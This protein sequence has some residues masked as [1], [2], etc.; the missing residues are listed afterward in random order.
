MAKALLFWCKIFVFA[1]LSLISVMVLMRLIGTEKLVGTAFGFVIGIVGV[2]SICGYFSSIYKL[3]SGM[4]SSLST[5]FTILLLQLIPFIGIP[6]GIS[7]MIKA[8]G[9]GNRLI[10]ESARDDQTLARVSDA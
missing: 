2:V 6:L 8:F 9:K 4:G 1:L 10:A 3:S 5:T 7:V